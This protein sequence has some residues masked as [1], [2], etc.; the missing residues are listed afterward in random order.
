MLRDGHH[1]SVRVPKGEHDVRL[2]WDATR[3][4]V[5]EGLWTPNFILPC[6]DWLCRLLTKMSWQGDLDVGECFN[7]FPLHEKERKHCGWRS[8]HTVNGE[9]LKEIVRWT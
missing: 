7:N 5:N 8:C 9:E 2:V 1:A 3:N 4:G 6:P